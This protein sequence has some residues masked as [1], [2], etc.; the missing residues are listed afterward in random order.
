[1]LD[2]IDTRIS[3]LG[4]GLRHLNDELAPTLAQISARLT[5]ALLTEGRIMTCGV[6]QQS[7]LAQ[8]FASQ[9]NHK[10]ERDRPS[11]PALC[12]NTD[13]V[14]MSSIAAGSS[15]SDIYAHQLRA[16]AQPSD[17]LLIL[18]DNGSETACIKALTAAQDRDIGSVVI[19]GASQGAMASLIG[20]ED[21]SLQLSSHSPA[22]LLP[23]QLVC[24]TL[25]QDLIEHQLFG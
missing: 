1:M 23:L 3:G 25:L 6:G 9:L 4:A 19:T 11:L 7:A 16:H 14:L 17:V 21:Q 8:M 13:S 2:H 10:L 15:G 12:L 18:S 24:I 22:E 20:H 5:Q